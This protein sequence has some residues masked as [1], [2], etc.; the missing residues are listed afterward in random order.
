MSP[1]QQV[2]VTERIDVF[3]PKFSVVFAI[4]KCDPAPFYLFDE[5]FSQLLESVFH[6]IRLRRLMLT[7][8]LSIEQL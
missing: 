8:T 3:Y 7:W 5:V 4:Q 6:L 1:L 2:R